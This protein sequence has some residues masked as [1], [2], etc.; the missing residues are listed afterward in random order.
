[1]FYKIMR[2]RKYYDAFRSNEAFLK[3]SAKQKLKISLNILRFLKTNL[4]K[5]LIIKNKPVIAQIEPT[6]ECNLQC[7]M[8]IRKEIGVPIG[9]MSFENFKKILD[10]LDSLFKIHL[11]GQ[12]EPFLNPDIFKMIEYANKKGIIV[13]FTTNGTCLT[14]SVIDKICSVEIGEIGVSIDSPKKEEYEKIRKGAKF[15]KVLE[16]VKNLAFELKRKKKKTIVSIA[17]VILKDNID[18]LVEFVLLTKKLGVSKIGFQ[19]MQEKTDYLDKY[20]SKTK[21]QA[22]SS[23]NKK[24]KENID[25]A[26]KIAKKNNI[27]LIFDEEKSPGCIWPWRSVYI[28]WNGYVTPCCKILDYREPYFGNILKEDFWKIWNGKQYQMYR[29]LLRDRKAPFQCKGCAMV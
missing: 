13:Y 21:S 20:D 29:K 5:P 9:T 19:T 27:T 3:T 10:K 1:M 16:N 15:E 7:E 17:S 22:V 6:S 25:K 2:L 18:D 26:K 24:L 12:G 23:L 14:K 4:S 11:S 28:S 8:C